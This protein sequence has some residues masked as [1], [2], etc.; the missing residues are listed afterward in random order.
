[1]L[2]W[3]W[4]VP[5]LAGLFIYAAIRRKQAV[6]AFG[7]GAAFVSR[8]REAFS[9]CAAITLIL[10][11]LARPAWDVQEQQ[12]QETG[13][14]V[15]FLLDVSRSMLA[16]DMH[17]NRLENAKTAIL[18]CVEAL[19]G[20]RVGLVL[21]AGSAEIRC[22]LTADYDYFRMALRQA[23][24]ES[25]TVGGTMIA[26]A[27][28]KVVDKLIH[29]EKAGLQDLILITDGEDMI[30][31]SDEI[32]AART[33]DES[34]VRLIAIG[35]GDR[36]RGSRISLEDKETGAL[37]FMK[38]DNREIWTKLHSETLRKMSAVVT[39]GTYF[40]VASGPFD[41]KQ[42]YRQVMEHAQRT[43]VEKQV[44]ESYEEKFH[45]FLGG[46]VLVLL[47]SNRWKL[48]SMHVL[49][50]MLLLTGMVH[51][52]P[53]GLFREGNKAFAAGRFDAAAN[54]YQEAAAAAPESAEIYYNL[55]NAQYRAER[56]EEAQSAFEYA[57]AQARTDALRSQSWYNMA[58]CLIKTAE[59]LRE[60]EPQAAVHYCRQAAWLY[61]TALD[62]NSGFSD[63]AYNLEMTQH[64]AASIVEEIRAQEEKEQQEN[65]LIQYI[66]QKLEEFIERQTQLIEKNMD[67]D[68]QRILETDTRELAQVM[69]DSGLHTEIELPDGSEI[70]GPLK[71]TFEHT[72]K[73][74]DA[75]AVP[76]QPVALAELIA[77]LGA[78]PEDP[79]QQDG[80]SDE[81]SE[82]YEDYDMDYE[83][84][85]ED[86]DM[87]EEADPFGDFSEYE[88][89]RGVPPPNQTEM[90]IL[91]EELLN[92][93]RRKE[94]KAGEY[95]SVEKDW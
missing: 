28:E 69:D 50:C 52:N 54:A 55:G 36:T 76:D 31:G 27:I 6:N 24:P 25:V 67:G 63:A 74:A 73:A 84:S 92:Q 32:E 91:A 68:P 78:A 48:R 80:E 33:L 72:L 38:H 77:A 75:M 56:F 7:A 43:S 86:A 9:S 59:I 8:K 42:I 12:L 29:P 53:A 18:D 79:D 11:S 40:E 88:E 44:L 41:L 3:L 21:F 37:S 51:A 93:E 30:E 26:N 81:D 39:G 17:P 70:P 16:E 85:D 66:R 62:Y 45:L 49:L 90:D 83:E 95:K 61:R 22:P 34:G 35:I 94:K 65:E 82:D 58:N 14:D 89:I 64:I 1:M 71:E 57:A 60:S 23:T 20:D 5:V 47:F 2:I 13:R 87:Y 10:L 19:S 46:A 15:I 4:L